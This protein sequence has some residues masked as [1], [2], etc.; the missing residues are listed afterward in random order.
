MMDCWSSELAKLAANAM[1]AQR[2]TNINSLS[3][4]CE[5]TG[6]NIDSVA[7]ACGLDPR[8][9]PHMLQS[10]LGWGGGCFQKDILDLVYIARS[11]KLDH[12]ADY[13]ASVI[14]INVYQQER[15]V[16]RIISAM[17][18]SVAGR[19]IAVLG[20]AFKKDTSDSKNSPAMALVRGLLEE[21]ANVSIYDPLVPPTS[22]ISA[23][24]LTGD[25]AFRVRVC[26]SPY[27]ACHEAD[28]VI[29]ATE[30]AEFA[31]PSSPPPKRDGEVA[32]PLTPPQEKS[33]ALDWAHIASH[34]RRPRYVF[35]G[36]NLLDG[37]YLAQLGCR[38]ARVGRASVWDGRRSDEYR[39]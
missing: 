20:F 30:C 26:A 8:I 18:G 17:Y 24:Q 4:I 28:A 35:D 9:G 29:V 31:T 10:G 11:L 25:A 37:E 1:L 5:A 15:F 2:V 14:D 3:A 19:S 32:L 27:E 12:V 38:Y 6:A 33:Q 36:R 7:E 16:K 39:A 21:R 22:V 23:L 34:M 13:W